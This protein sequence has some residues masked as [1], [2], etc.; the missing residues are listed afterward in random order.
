MRVSKT[1]MPKV[2]GG[3]HG[4]RSSGGRRTMKGIKVTEAIEACNLVLGPV[5]LHK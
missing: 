5:I 4:S 3:H 2:I 1:L